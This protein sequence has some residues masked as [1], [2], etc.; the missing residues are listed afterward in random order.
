MDSVV[1]TYDVEEAA[2]VLGIGR[3]TAYK[4]IDEGQIPHL[5]LGKKIR[6][7]KIA[8]DRMLSGEPK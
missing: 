1:A 6:I 4:L 8:I 3:N 2:K 5:R 7:P